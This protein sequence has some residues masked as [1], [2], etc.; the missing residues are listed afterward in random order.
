MRRAAEA[1]HHVVGQVDQRRDRPLARALEPRL[2]PVGRG[3]VLHA[4]DRPGRRTPGSLRDRRCGF[5]RGRGKLPGDRLDAR[6][7]ERAQPRRG[8]VAG[9]AVD[10]HAVG[11]VG[12]D[13]DVEHRVSCPA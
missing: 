2:Q 3:A 11:P 13:R 10:A 8:E 12:G 5:R 4:A 9:D 6:R 1:E 7:L